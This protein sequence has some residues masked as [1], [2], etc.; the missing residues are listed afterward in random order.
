MIKIPLP[1][2]GGKLYEAFLTRCE[3]ASG[4]EAASFI[5]Y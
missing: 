5:D 2:A 4:T 1:P 3:A